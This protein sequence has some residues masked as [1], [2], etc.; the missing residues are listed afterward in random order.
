MAPFDDVLGGDG[1]DGGDVTIIG[2]GTQNAIGNTVSRDLIMHFHAGR[3][4]STMGLSESEIAD[5]VA[6][7]VRAGNHDL[8]VDVLRRDRVVAL[9]GD[10]GAGVTTTAVAAARELRPD[11]PV[12]PL[13]SAEDDAEEDWSVDCVYLVRAADED[14]AS[15]LRSRLEVVLG[16]SRGIVLVVGT[17]AELRRFAE[18]LRPVPV[19]PPS[20]DA[21]YRRRL[22][23]CGLGGTQWPHWGRAADLLKGASP[24]DGRRLADLV[25][26][27]GDAGEAERAYR[28]WEEQLRGWF[29]DYP[30]LRNRALLIAAAA[31]APAGESS[32][33]GAALSLARHLRINVEGGGLAWCPSAELSDLLGADREDD[34]ILFRR[35]GYASSVLRHACRDYPLVRTDLL[36]WLSELPTDEAVGLDAPLQRR[37]ATVFADLAA[38]ADLPSF[39][40]PTVSEWARRGLADLAYLALVGTC[41]HPVVGGRVRRFLYEWS[42]ERGTP[43]TLKL[44]IVRVCQVLG[45]TYPSVALTRLK[46]LAAN[47]DQQVRDEVVDAA[48]ELAAAHGEEVAKAALAWCGAAARFTSER[49][50]ARLAGVALRVLLALPDGAGPPRAGAVLDAVARLA[51]CGPGVRAVALEAALRLA[52]VHRGA[53][54]RAALVWAGAGDDPSPMGGRLSM[55]GAELFLKLAGLRGADGLAAVLTGPGAVEPTAC[56][57]A[58][59]ALLAMETLARAG[60]EGVPE[61]IMLWLDTAEARPDLRPRIVGLFTSVAVR[62]PASRALMVELAR[63]WAGNARDRRG[64]RDDVLVVLLLPEWKRLLLMVWVEVRR[65]VLGGG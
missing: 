33:Y 4:R 21:V 34:R 26:E 12:R 43:Q 48:V 18:F 54:L 20:A 62:D 1:R 6:G 17:A 55:F 61:A 9:A 13:S 44:T 27:T 22:D 41:L 23:V 39:I 25:R 51:V 50:A 38:A 11:L 53:V 32:V 36:A 29:A 58:W 31:I 59:S 28:E 7:Y 30:D 14:D 65:R 60:R 52:Q 57:S 42:K 24:A 3:A 47:G 19:Q 45:G 37:V 10:E 64:I 15:R 16:R 56:A 35:H 63:A 5:R 2:D 40:R 46:H 8:I 49:D